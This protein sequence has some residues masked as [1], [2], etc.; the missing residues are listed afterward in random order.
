MH[1]GSSLDHIC[2]QH[3]SIEVYM[4]MSSRAKS[5]SGLLTQHVRIIHTFA[6]L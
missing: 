3:P 2:T 6:I 5:I 4:Y 1:A